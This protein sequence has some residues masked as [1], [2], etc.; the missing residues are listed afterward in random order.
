MGCR[1]AYKIIS[2]GLT[3]LF[4]AALAS[5]AAREAKQDRQTEV[6]LV[7]AGFNMKMADTPAKLAH[8]KTLPQRTI[9]KHKKDGRILY[10]YADAKGCKCLCY[11]D[12]ADYQRFNNL[13]WNRER[14]A[15][16]AKMEAISMNENVFI[17]NDLWGPWY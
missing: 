8:L 14:S 10:F 3:V 6:V 9:F 2:L 13:A 1:T 16:D 7:S 17:D 4:L 15:G 5:C 12:R 11:G